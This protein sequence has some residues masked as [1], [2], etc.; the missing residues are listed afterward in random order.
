MKKS[1]IA[2]AALAASG[3][4][5][6]VTVTG[7]LDAGYQIT[8]AE[9][10]ASDKTTI[11]QSGSATTA[12]IIT[13]TEDLGGGMKA[14]FRYEMNPDFVSGTGLSSATTG[15]N[16]YNN[17][18]LSGSFG[19]V[20]FGRLNTATLA[21][22]GVANPFGTNVG[23]GYST[24]TH[25]FPAA[26]SSTMATAPT[27]FNNA[28]KYATPNMSGF[29]AQVIYVPK[30]D[31][32]TVSADKNNQGV[33][34]LGLGYANGPLAVQVAHMTIEE[35]SNAATEI[36]ALGASQ[37]GTLTTVAGSY[38][39]MPALKL[40]AAYNTTKVDGDAADAT[41]LRLSGTYT[42]GAVAL[43]ATWA[44]SDDKT[45]TNADRTSFGLGADYN[46]SAKTALYVRYE[47]T[48][49][50]TVETTDNKT[51]TTMAGLR[52]KF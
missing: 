48:N 23:S 36:V 16:G 6:Q 46:L 4:F 32:S 50:K 28:F 7:V 22:N 3:A 24:M 10:T 49:A 9:G 2:L 34:E 15:A 5:A 8:D 31:N 47:N 25:R 11:A 52:V 14:G 26:T 21:A 37:K 44:N 40:G 27:R 35:G 43:M 1:L 29:S 45:T 13:G 19:A 18:N 42:M 51:T 41:G 17:V 38:Q 12:I 20:E 30:N 33:M 39:V